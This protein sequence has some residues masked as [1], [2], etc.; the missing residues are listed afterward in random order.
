MGLSADAL[1]AVDAER[2][3]PQT[4][5]RRQVRTGQRQVRDVLDDSR[6]EAQTA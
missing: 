4:L 3:E 6:D 2:V 1:L 5:N